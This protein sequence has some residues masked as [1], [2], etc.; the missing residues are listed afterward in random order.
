MSH[1]IQIPTQLNTISDDASEAFKP[2]YE[3]TE[4][5]ECV[6][7][8]LL[9]TLKNKLDGFQIYYAQEVLDFARVFFKP[10][11]KQREQDQRL[12]H[13]HIDP[14]VL[15]YDGEPEDRRTD[16]RHQLGTYLRLYS[17]LSQ[18]VNFHDID[19]ERLYAFGRLLITKLETPGACGPVDIADDVRLAYYRLSMTHEGNVALSPGETATVSGPTEV[20]TGRAKEQDTA[21]L[22]E[23]VSVLNDRFGTEF[24]KADQLWFDQIIEDMSGDEKLGDQARNNPIENFKLEFD[25]KVMEAVVN[26]IERNENI[27]TKF[28]SDEALREVAIRMMMQQVY[29]RLQATDASKAG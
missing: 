8:N 27:A 2:F 3:Q 17:F 11:E 4:V 29:E 24:T 9:Y 28:L 23:I 21:K 26:R 10:A 13:K 19:L 16:F 12:L 22:S 18:I 5:E 15:R 1:S 14:A 7:P 6:D 20:G 25:P